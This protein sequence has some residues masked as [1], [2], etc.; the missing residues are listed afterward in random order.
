MYI[1]LSQQQNKKFKMNKTLAKSELFQEFT[2]LN[3]QALE[4]KESLGK[5]DDFKRLFPLDLIWEAWYFY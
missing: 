1:K 5:D 3:T 2:K 4:D